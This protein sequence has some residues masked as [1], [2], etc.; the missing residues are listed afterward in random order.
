MEPLPIVLIALGAGAG[1]LGALL[2]VGGGVIL[3]PALVLLAGEPFPAAVGTSLVCVVATSV[4]GSAVHFRRA[5]VDPDTALRLQAFAALGAVGAALAAPFVP[6]RGLFVAFAALTVGAAWQLWPHAG[7][8]SPAVTA[9]HGALARAVAG[10]GGMIGGLLG[11]G[12][13][14]VFVP[15]LHGLAG[16]DFHRAAATSTY[17]IGL[18]AGSGAAV[19]LVRGDVDLP[20]VAPTMLGVLIG[21]SLA[22]AVAHRVSAAWLKR[23][24]ALLLVYVAVRMLLRAFAHA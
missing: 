1:I 15:L 8:P 16:L 14:I 5:M 13:G 2:G 24:F 12:G 19:Y 4:A 21:A 11:V 7:A 9:P 6:V 18:T 3:V 23:G 10:A 20:V 22:S 17:L